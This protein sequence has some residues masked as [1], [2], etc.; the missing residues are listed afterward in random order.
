MRENVKGG[1]AMRVLTVRQPYA[2]AIIHGGK[3]VENRV[4]GLGGYRGPVAILAGLTGADGEGVS[5]VWTAGLMTHDPDTRGAIIGVVDLAS[6]HRDE[7]PGPY[8]G[9]DAVCCESS[10]AMADCWH[11]VLENPRALTTPIS[12]AGALG[13]RILPD[14]IEAEIWKQIGEA[15]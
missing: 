9:S 12:Y 11:L 8:D 5:E 2:W 3:D 1:L 13:L 15:S 7:G 6:A 14:D 4:R 10:W